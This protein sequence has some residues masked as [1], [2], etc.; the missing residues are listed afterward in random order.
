MP[1]NFVVSRSSILWEVA[2][3]NLVS[4][5]RNKSMCS[6]L[7]QKPG[8]N[9]LHSDIAHSVAALQVETGETWTPGANSVH[10]NLAHFF[11]ATGHA[12]TG[13]TRTRTWPFCTLRPL[14]S[15]ATTLVVC[16]WSARVIPYRIFNTNYLVCTAGEISSISGYTGTFILY[17]TRLQF[18]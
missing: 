10:P 14:A 12:E 17:C 16:L 11:V 4:S 6:H 5:C 15:S 1:P 18:L 9:S 7:V 13:E 3:E 2:E 8:V